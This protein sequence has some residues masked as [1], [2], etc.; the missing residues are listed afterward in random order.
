MDMLVEELLSKDLPIERVFQ[1]YEVKILAAQ[2]ANKF[3]EAIQVALEV[4]RQ[5]GFKSIPKKPMKVTILREFIKTN[6][7]VKGRSAEELAALP[8]LT[9]EK[10]AMGMQMLELVRRHIHFTELYL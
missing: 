5:L 9:N 6:K 10:V 7:A 4:R 8:I 3:D 2:A 1:A